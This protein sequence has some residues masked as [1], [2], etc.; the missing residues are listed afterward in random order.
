MVRMAD[1]RDRDVVNVNDGKR[2][3]IISD[4]EVDVDRGRIKAIV[5]P[6]TG[7]FMGVL[8]RR[9]DLVIPWDQIVKVGVDTILVDYPVDMS[10]D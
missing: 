1:L 6:G 10:M 7:G 5:I 4:I 8:S 3:G 9:H 2:L